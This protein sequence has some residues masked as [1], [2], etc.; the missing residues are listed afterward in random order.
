MPPTR[1][2]GSDDR[3]TLPEPERP[4]VSGLLLPVAI[5]NQGQWRTATEVPRGM[6]CNCCCPGCDQPVIAR[7]GTRRRPHFAHLSRTPDLHTCNETAL[8]RLCKHIVCT[9]V[10]KC[11]ALPRTRRYNVRLV[12]VA[13]EVAIDVVAR[14]VDLLAEVSFEC[15]KGRTSAGTSNLAIEICVSHN[16]DQSYCLDMKK[17]GVPAVEIAVTWQQVL[18]RITKTPTQARVE[19]ALR[20]LILSMTG[21]KRWLHRKDMAIC[22]YCQQYELPDHKTNGLTCGLIPCPTCDS[23]MRQDSKYNKCHRCRGTLYF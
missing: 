13:P 16:K 19:S 22:P 2:R 7:Q 18:D 20:F 14:R 10:D 17:A 1:L 9:S 5:D 4:D 8:H 12:S 15:P 21:N 3:R 11:I 23:Y 6:A